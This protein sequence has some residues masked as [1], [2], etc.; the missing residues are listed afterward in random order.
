MG[1]K[2]TAI[3]LKVKQVVTMED[4][5]PTEEAELHKTQTVNVTETERE[6]DN[7]QQCGKM[8]RRAAKGRGDS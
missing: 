1:K 8:R 2:T 7:E 6:T 4:E 5:M 3:G